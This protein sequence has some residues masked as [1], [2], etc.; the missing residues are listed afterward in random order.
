[1]Y[2]YVKI[3]HYCTSVIILVVALACPLSLRRFLHTASPVCY[4]IIIISARSVT[5]LVCY[6]PNSITPTFTETSPR[7]KSWTQITKVA[8]TNHFDMSRCLR[9]S[10]W[11]VRDKPVCVAL[12]E[13]SPLQCKGKVGDKVGDKVCRLCRGHKSRKFA[14]QIMKVR[15]K[16]AT[17]SGTCPGLCRKVGVMEFGL[18]PASPSCD[19]NRQFAT[20]RKTWHK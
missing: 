4:Q 7:G 11:Q 9:Q 3:V 12:M 15:D 18:I 14:T 5:S 19:I 8:D 10:T 17:L 1:V 13:F 20:S 2:A 16:F 6:S